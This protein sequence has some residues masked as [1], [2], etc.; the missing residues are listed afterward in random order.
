MFGHNTLFKIGV[1]LPLSALVIIILGYFINCCNIMCF[2]VKIDLLRFL[3]RMVETTL[4][5]IKSP[6]LGEMPR[7]PSS[8]EPRISLV[9]LQGQ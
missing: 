9:H 3:F 4:P 6:L 1:M 5:R 8:T 2:F 7:N